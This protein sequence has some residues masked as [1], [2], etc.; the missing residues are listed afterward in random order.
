MDITLDF[1]TRR[2]ICEQIQEQIREKIR[3]KQLQ[4]GSQLPAV[5]ELAA[6]LQIN[7]NTVARAYRELDREGWISTQQGRGTYVLGLPP[8]PAKPQTEPEQI[9]EKLID[10]FIQE[11]LRCGIPEDRLWEA[12][13][14]AMRRLRRRQPRFIKRT[15]KRE[16]RISRPRR[17]TA[18]GQLKENYLKQYS[19]R[20]KKRSIRFHVKHSR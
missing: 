12:A 4:A 20:A 7:F 15:T 16:T 8:E 6:A 11:A 13:G 10:N 18:K 3:G 1:R 9:L 17:L 14:A 2:P 5:R 19:K